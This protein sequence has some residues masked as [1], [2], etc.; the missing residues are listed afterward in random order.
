MVG[1][2]T[3][4]VA[5]D[6]VADFEQRL[7]AL[8]AVAAGVEHADQGT[9][10]KQRTIFQT[11]TRKAGETDVSHKDLGSINFIEMCKFRQKKV[12]RY[13]HN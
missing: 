8:P 2:D 5:G 12:G 6:E 3:G 4:H 10:A 1:L 13:S 7:R 9:V 11:Q